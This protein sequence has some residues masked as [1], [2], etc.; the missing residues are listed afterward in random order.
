MAGNAGVN[1]KSGCI[2]GSTSASLIISIDAFSFRQ[3]GYLD[4]IMISQVLHGVAAI[5][6]MQ[7]V[8]NAV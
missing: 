2:D 4:V 6:S 3:Y 8:M 1:K 5:K 7:A